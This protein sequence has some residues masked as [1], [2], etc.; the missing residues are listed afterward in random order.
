MARME[1]SALPGP[2]ADVLAA[3]SW[4][5]TVSL[6]PT[7][8]GLINRTWWVRDHR[9]AIAAVLQWVNTA[10]FA[11]EVHED[12]EAVTSHVAARGLA[13]PRIVRTRAGALWHTAT[14]GGVYRVLTSV[15]DR[16]VDTLASA[17]ETRAAGHL[18]A[19]FHAAVADLDWQ[20]RNVRPG[21]HD[22]PRHM[23]RL[24]AGVSTL[25]DHRLHRAVAPLA[26][27]VIARW[28]ELP[29]GP[30]LPTR[31]VHGDLKVSNV[32]FA[33]RD[34]VALIDLDTVSHGTLDAE[35]GDAFR[36]WC[37]PAAE[38]DPAPAFALD[39]FAA[40]VEGYAAGASRNGPTDDEWAS[41]V[42][43]V[44]RITLELSARFAV[45][46]LEE[47]YFGWDA[48]RFATRGDHNLVRATNQLA[49]A[50]HIRDA[51]PAAA[52]AL[53]RARSGHRPS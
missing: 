2:P 14:D 35:L 42:P 16:T 4:P 28:S 41:I 10:V 3:W 36:S 23:A 29:A 32:R 6:E 21:V 47:R 1:R 13:T 37:N 49:L 39:L 51:T 7:D 20:F 9:G 38:D 34:A 48:T 25:R 19:R 44:E 53:D 17:D 8:G 33:G 45:D 15:G 22:T 30:T 26:S 11:P 50:R 40:A 52:R 27:E 5:S 18:V 12:I 31:I 24:E 43:G 46:A